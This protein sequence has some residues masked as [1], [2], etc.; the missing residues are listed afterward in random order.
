[1]KA[2]QYLE[3]KSM[4][5]VLARNGLKS[6]E[7][8]IKFLSSSSAVFTL[9]GMAVGFLPKRS[10]YRGLNIVSHTGLI[11]FAALSITN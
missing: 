10:T 6:K 9:V 2:F 3:D 11:R 1:M 7:Q 4:H 5:P 8:M